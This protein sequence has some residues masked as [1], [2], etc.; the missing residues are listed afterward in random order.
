[1]EWE[2]LIAGVLMMI[3]L[4]GLGFFMWSVLSL[5]VSLFTKLI[6]LMFSH[7]ILAAISI[8]SFAAIIIVMVLKHR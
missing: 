3:A 6:M 1:M 4:G 8:V 5:F 2:L 7:Q